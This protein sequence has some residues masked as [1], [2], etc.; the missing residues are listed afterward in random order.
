MTYE[1]IYLLLREINE[2]IDFPYNNRKE[3]GR[4]VAR[5]VRKMAVVVD[6]KS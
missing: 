5:A 3:L 4:R 6:K 2:A 1:Q